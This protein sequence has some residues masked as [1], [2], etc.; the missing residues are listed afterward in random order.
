MKRMQENT[1]T[2]VH[3]GGRIYEADGKYLVCRDMRT[4]EQRFRRAFSHPRYETLKEL[5]IH[6]VHV[7]PDGKGILLLFDLAPSGYKTVGNL[8]Y[9][10]PA[11]EVMWW[12]ELTDTGRDTYVA[13]RISA[14]GIVAQSWDGYSCEI[15]PKTGH[16]VSKRFTK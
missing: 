4:G 15:D 10:T 3:I 5:D 14:N 11:G 6:E 7:S 1:K 2:S 16:I 8:A 13:V 9:V 12:A